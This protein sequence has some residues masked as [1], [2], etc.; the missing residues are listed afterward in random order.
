M[1]TVAVT[2]HATGRSLRTVEKI[3]QTHQQAIAQLDPFQ[4]PMVSVLWSAK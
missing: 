1:T 3:A 2:I 4:R